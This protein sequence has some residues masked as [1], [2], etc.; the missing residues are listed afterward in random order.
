MARRFSS[1]KVRK[2]DDEKQ[3]DGCVSIYAEPDSRRSCKKKKE[4]LLKA[5]K[6]QLDDINR[7]SGKTGK[8]I[9]GKQT[10]R[11]NT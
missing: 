8:S 9:D 2:D 1:K 6:L 4:T 7:Q 5:A 3:L 10:M 11:S